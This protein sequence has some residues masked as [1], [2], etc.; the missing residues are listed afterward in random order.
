M[1]EMLMA[2]FFSCAKGNFYDLMFFIVSFETQIIA[3]C[4]NQLFLSSVGDRA[5]AM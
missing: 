1:H 4:E 3:E 2:F 5:F